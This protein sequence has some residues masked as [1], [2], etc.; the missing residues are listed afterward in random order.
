LGD[1]NEPGRISVTLK[2]DEVRG[3]DFS[4]PGTWIV[5]HG[6]PAEVRSQIT[7]T[8]GIADEGSL[9]DLISAAT[10]EFK[11]TGNVST[12][13]GGRV[14]GNGSKQTGPTGSG[15]AWDRAAGNGA[16]A[17]AEPEVDPNVTRVLAEIE[18]VTDVPALQQVYA[19]NKAVF[20][21]NEDV[22]AAY[23]AKG[24]SLS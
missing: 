10:S 17:P 14:I 6:S 20:D 8:F 12:G 18:A 11:A 23:K 21:A 13:L 1:P 19:R 24:K 3:R 9:A 5:F 15:S 4:S 22:L 7:E 2:Q 16:E